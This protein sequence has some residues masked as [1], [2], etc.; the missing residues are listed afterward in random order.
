MCKRHV[1]KHIAELVEVCTRYG[2]LTLPEYELRR[3]IFKYMN[4]RFNEDELFD[5]EMAWF[6]SEPDGGGIFDSNP[7]SDMVSSFEE[8]E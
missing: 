5:T 7:I 8:D 3:K 4:D 6:L 2:A 1:I